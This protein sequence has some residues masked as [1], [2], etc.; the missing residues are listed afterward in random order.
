MSRAPGLILRESS[1]DFRVEEGGDEIIQ[2][3]ERTV[4]QL[5]PNIFAEHRTHCNDLLP[6]FQLPSEVLIKIISLSI[7]D[8][9]YGVGHVAKLHSFAQVSTQFANLIKSSP[10]LWNIVSTYNLSEFP[11]IIARSKDASLDILYHGQNHPTPAILVFQDTVLHQSHR[12]RSVVLSESGLEFGQRLMK[13]LPAPRLRTLRVTHWAHGPLEV[14][15]EQLVGL[16]HLTLRVAFVNVGW[17]LLSGLERLELSDLRDGGRPS[18]TQILV[19][20]SA[21]PKLYWLELGSGSLGDLQVDDTASGS[22]E[23]PYLECLKLDLQ[24]ETVQTILTYLRFPNCTDMAITA[25][26]PSPPSISITLPTHA[27]SQVCSIIVAVGHLKIKL[28]SMSAALVAGPVGSEALNLILPLPPVDNPLRWVDTILGSIQVPPHSVALEMQFALVPQPIVPTPPIPSHI[29][30][31]TSL[32]L[33]GCGEEVAPWTK[34]LS[35]PAR[36]G[37]EP[38][39]WHLPNLED[40]ILDI[41]WENLAKALLTMIKCRYG[42]RTQLDVGSEPP[43]LLA[44]SDDQGK[45]AGDGY[46]DHKTFPWSTSSLRLPVPLKKLTIR[47]SAD[48][49]DETVEELESIIGLG[50]VSWEGFIWDDSDY[51]ECGYETPPDVFS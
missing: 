49:S 50:K 36:T 30:H 41:W 46:N 45:M 6:L 19:V 23:L 13:Q 2:Q 5:D 24:W 27:I 11:L 37:D 32:R 4:D 9:I 8:P 21:S 16:H 3:V 12:W 26:L 14:R 47:G 31:I 29:Y 15:G 35:E 17:S 43:G 48:I 34:L 10:S 18:L 40:L 42:D 20:L 1:K 7:Y 28:T 38:A 39:H 22:L 33:G 44:E 25:C 51:E